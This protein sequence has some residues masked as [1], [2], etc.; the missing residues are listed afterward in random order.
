M[1]PAIIDNRLLKEKYQIFTPADIVYEML[2]LA[3][4]KGKL[5]GKKVLENSCGNGEFLVQIVVR[6]VESCIDIGLSKEE[7][8][9]GLENDIFAY[10]IDAARIE[11]CI[12][13]LNK[14]IKRFN[15]PKVRWKIRNEDFLESNR[16]EKFDYII[17]NPPYIAY[18]NLPTNIQQYLKEHFQSCKKG[19]FDYCYAFVEK[20]FHCLGEKGSLVY[21]VPSNIFKNVFAAKL[22][23]L[24][25]SDLEIVVDYPDDCIFE[26]VLVS[27]AIIKLRK[28]ANLE[29]L[30]YRKNDYSYQL[31]KNVLGNKWN[32]SEAKRMAGTRIGEYFK[33]SSSVATLLNEA[34]VLK[35]GTIEDNYYVMGNNKIEMTMLR[36]AASPKNK[37]YKKFDEYII[38]PYDYN[39]YGELKHYSEEEMYKMF[40]LGMKFLESNKVKLDKRKAD[41][42]AK[43][44][45]YG[46]T[47]ALKSI[48]GPKI[49]ISSIISE[50]TQAYLLEKDEVPYSGL[51]I[52]S[53][54]KLS[55]D[56]LLPIL[57][58]E[59][60]KKY[61]YNVGIC[62]S[63]TSRRVTPSD[64]ENY[65]F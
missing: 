6:Y 42:N 52:V 25:K 51:Y 65:T 20:S 58:S 50:C 34:F 30:T 54:G 61:I 36:R 16:N 4:Y 35:N 22:R 24:I 10:E 60:F 15:V 57:N 18:P 9:T 62:V 13:R 45:E 7:I 27:P 2:E 32:F 26:K 64:I 11:E 19:K 38:F 49:L 3:N 63:G 59:S 56:E 5:F 44:F 53:T 29:Q 55:L 14:V 46:R 40:P 43:W 48:D 47:Q 39:E 21:I 17:G 23:E 8:K 1:M 41:N 28:N 31:D 12:E 37:K 33:V